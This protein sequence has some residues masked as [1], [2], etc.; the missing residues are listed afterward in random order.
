MSA[1]ANLVGALLLRGICA[2]G[3]CLVFALLLRLLP[4]L[5]TSEQGGESSDSGG[6]S[7]AVIGLTASALLLATLPLPT[8]GLELPLLGLVVAGPLYDP[9]LAILLLP[10]ASLGLW[11]SRLSAV[12]WLRA[13]LP[14][15]VGLLAANI[16]RGEQG[17]L[18]RLLALVAC[19]PLLL[20]AG[21]CGGVGGGL[22]AGAGWLAMAGLLLTSLLPGVGGSLTLVGLYLAVAFALVPLAQ[23]AAHRLPADSYLWVAALLAGLLGLLAT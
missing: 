12:E 10:L 18:V 1:F 11:R 15:A 8:F 17:W 6:E 23:L 7:E 9:L 21:G 19:L 20:A 14:A 4:R 3:L 16:A 13:Y 5:T 22:A 2:L